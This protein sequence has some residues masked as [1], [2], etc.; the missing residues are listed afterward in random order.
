[1]VFRGQLAHLVKKA[2]EVL[3]VIREQLVLRAQWEKGVLPVIVVF[4]DLMVCLD[5]RAL[6][7]SA[8]LWGLQDLKEARETQDVQASPAFQALGV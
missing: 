4:Q 6:K 5:Q 2:K 1:M 7:E 8:A 3:E